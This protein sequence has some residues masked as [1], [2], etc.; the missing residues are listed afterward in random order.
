MMSAVR[1]RTVIG[2][3]EAYCNTAARCRELSGLY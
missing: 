1:G 3:K 2:G